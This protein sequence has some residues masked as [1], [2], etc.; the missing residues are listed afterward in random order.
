MK[1]NEKLEILNPDGLNSHKLK[2]LK[3]FLAGSRSGIAVCSNCGKEKG[4]GW[5]YGNFTTSRES[6]KSFPNDWE[7][8]DNR[9]YCDNCKGK[10]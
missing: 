5:E 6:G 2:S 3:H 9:F 4:F 10:L 8:I 7:I 1:K